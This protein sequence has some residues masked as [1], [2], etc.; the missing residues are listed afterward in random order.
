M[1]ELVARFLPQ[2]VTSARAHM[3]KVDGWMVRR[4]QAEKR[5]P[6]REIH[7]IK[8]DAGMLELS[9]VALLARDCEEKL[10]QLHA[11]STDADIAQLVA[12][13]RQL[14]DVIAGIEAAHLSKAGRP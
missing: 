6:L 8:G 13:L 3:A 14:E 5:V 9:E 10:K 11:D 7:S 1:D 2:F 12:A 4:D